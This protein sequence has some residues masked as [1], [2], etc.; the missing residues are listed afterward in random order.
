MD[1]LTLLLKINDA[2]TGWNTLSIQS[3]LD[4]QEKVPQSLKVLMANSFQFSLNQFT[5]KIPSEIRHCYKF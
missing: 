4:I 2:V 1:H 5:P 3:I